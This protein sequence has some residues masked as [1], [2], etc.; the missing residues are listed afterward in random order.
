MAAQVFVMVH[1]FIGMA[2]GLAALWTTVELLNASERNRRRIVIAATVSAVFVWLVYVWGGHVY[3]IFYAQ[4]KAQVLAGAWP[5]AHNFFMRFKE[6]AFFMLL[7]LATYLPMIVRRSDLLTARG[8]RNLALGVALLVFLLAL[9]MEG[10]GA[11]V[12]RGIRL[13]LPGG[14]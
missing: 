9:S 7:L 14:A 11:V 12:D 13:G 1:A 5:W 8:A 3:L 6:H 4:H 2:G 10:S